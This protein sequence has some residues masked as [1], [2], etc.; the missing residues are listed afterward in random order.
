MSTQ[1]DVSQ[2]PT[3]T[4][5]CKVHAELL[6]KGTGAQRTFHT[7]HSIGAQHSVPKTREHSA[8]SFLRTCHN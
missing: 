1:S 7:G 2:K 4:R 3:L 8:S 5:C 6:E